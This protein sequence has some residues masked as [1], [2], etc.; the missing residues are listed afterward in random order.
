M[1]QP[2]QFIPGGMVLPRLTDGD[3]GTM[4]AF[5]AQS[6]WE[7]LERRKPSSQTL[8]ERRK[9]SNVAF[10]VEANMRQWKYPEYEEVAKEPDITR[11]CIH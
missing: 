10:S 4:E 7:R 11:C 6:A 5:Q 8:S 3:G 9:G 2:R 1:K